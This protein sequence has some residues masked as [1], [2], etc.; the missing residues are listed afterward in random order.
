[1]PKTPPP[2]VCG[3]GS[4]SGSVS[5]GVGVGVGLR[6]CVHSVP[7]TTLLNPGDCL[8]GLHTSNP[9]YKVSHQNGDDYVGINLVINKIT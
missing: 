4:G 7:E 5:V 8:Y 3:S 1:M 9:T 6:M 2:M